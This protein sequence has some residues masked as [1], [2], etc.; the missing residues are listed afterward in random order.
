[1]AAYARETMAEDVGRLLDH[2]SI[3]EADLM[4]YSM[5]GGLALRL[6][7]AATERFNAVIPA[8]VGGVDARS[9]ESGTRDRGC[10]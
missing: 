1:M 5:G 8:G 2:L 9:H 3:D 10:P 4:G 6:L 7:S